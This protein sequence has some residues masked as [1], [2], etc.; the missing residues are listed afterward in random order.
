MI[1]FKSKLPTTENIVYTEWAV[2]NVFKD[3][4]IELH[5]DLQLPEYLE[6]REKIIEHERGHDFKKGFFHNLYIDFF[7][8]VGA[9]GILKFMFQRPKTWIQLL[10]IYYSHRRGI[11][12]DK[13][14]LFFYIAIFLGL[15]VFI[16]LMEVI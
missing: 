7:A 1:F 4:T 16:K 11:V 14:M 2:A 3:G 12:Y 13:I 9:S 6:L 15:F 10:P 8:Y 5:Q